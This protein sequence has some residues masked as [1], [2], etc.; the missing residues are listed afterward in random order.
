MKKLLSLVFL[1]LGTTLL[2]SQDKIVKTNSDTVVCKVLEVGAS[3]VQYKLWSNLAGATEALPLSQV[4]K[5][6]YEGGEEKVYTLPKV[7]E[8]KEEKPKKD[9]FDFGYSRPHKKRD[10]HHWSNK[11]Q[12]G[13][14]AS[15]ATASIST[16]SGSVVEVNAHYAY[17]FNKRWSLKAYASVGVGSDYGT[18]NYVN[19]NSDLTSAGAGV[20]MYYNWISR[21]RFILHSGLGLGFM[22]WESYIYSMTADPA[23]FNDPTFKGYPSEAAVERDVSYYFD[24]AG[25]GVDLEVF[26]MDVLFGDHFGLYGKFGYGYAGLAN[27]GLT[28][29]W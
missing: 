23:A 14:G 10:I 8:P 22:A 18:T 3:E 29:A 25:L 6:I 5:I 15:Y 17:H 13:L 7:E 28:W 20:G 26:G 21:K 19:W 16:Y 9:L 24:Y 4:Y 12:I 27:F 1:L 2:Y 11:H